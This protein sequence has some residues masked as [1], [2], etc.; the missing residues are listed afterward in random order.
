[1]SSELHA[2]SGINVR[3]YTYELPPERI[4]YYPLEPRDSSGLLVMQN[5]HIHDAI[6]RDIHNIIEPGSLL[7]MNNTKVVQARLEFFKSTGARIEIFC[8]EPLTPVRDIQLALACK[9]PVR[10]LC[11]VGNLRKWKSGVL[12][13]QFKGQTL[14]AKM[15]EQQSDGMVI[16]FSWS[17]GALSFAEL[18]DHMGKMPLP[19]YISRAA[20]KSDRIGYQT[21]FAMREGSVAAPT[22]GLHFSPQLLDSIKGKGIAG[23]YVTLHVGAGTFKP[24]TTET[25]GE[26]HMHQEQ[27]SVECS[28]IER[29]SE[30]E[31]PLVCVGTTSM[32]TLE[33]LYWIGLQIYN[34]EKP[35]AEK[36]HLSQWAPYQQQGR[37]PGKREVLKSLLQWAKAHELKQVKGE[38][39]LIIVPGYSFQ[40]VDV[41]VTNFHQPGSTLLLLVAA[42]VG[43]DWKK[44][45]QHALLHDYRFLSYGDGC[46]FYRKQS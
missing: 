4:A 19:P 44:V 37:L 10:W 12:S 9:S 27:F 24:V 17:D 29:L 35:D 6:F 41:L 13:M 8:L 14:E 30:H 3:D 42:F 43:D 36:L 7:V 11:L 34:G 16:E 5:G 26:H 31:K 46:L 40:L 33:S 15:I 32:R 23:E 18:L 38:T 25:I 39:S 22:A 20:E 21:V 28:L 45:Y 1:M 2:I